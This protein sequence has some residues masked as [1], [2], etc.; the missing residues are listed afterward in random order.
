MGSLESRLGDLLGA[1]VDLS[2]ANWMRESIRS[3]A[4]SEAVLA[5]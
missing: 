5:F 1:K 4:L 3:Q 2:S